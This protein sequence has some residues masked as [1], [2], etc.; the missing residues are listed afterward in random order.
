MI[1]MTEL[2]KDMRSCLLENDL[3]SFGRIL[4]ENWLLKKSMTGAISNPLVDKYYDL[5]M[6]AGAGGGK[7]LGAG[8]G[9][10]LLFYCEPEHQLRLRS[11]LSDLVELPFSMET[12]GTKVIY[13]GEKDW[14]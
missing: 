2:A 14:D 1:R 10:F 3:S 4:H 7:L 13:V 11:A 9:G 12:G 8:G 6:D 5:A